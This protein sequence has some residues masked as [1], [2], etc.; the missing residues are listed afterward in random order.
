M[1]HKHKGESSKPAC[2]DFIIA[3]LRAIRY[4]PSNLKKGT[5]AG[6]ALRRLWAVTSSAYSEKEFRASLNR[7]LGDGTLVATWRISHTD[8][9]QGGSGATE[10]DSPAKIVRIDSIPVGMPLNQYRSCRGMDGQFF[11][12][13]RSNPVEHDYIQ[14]IYVYVAADGLPQKVP[15][16]AR[17]SVASTAD[18]I[19]AAM[20]TSP[21]RRR[22]S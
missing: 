15:G 2:T 3:A 21:K 16:V 7:L 11:T 5:K 8:V 1:T 9:I 13:D 12:Y 19:I 14:G 6:V 10:H 4:N 20:R 22:R 18:Q 17:L